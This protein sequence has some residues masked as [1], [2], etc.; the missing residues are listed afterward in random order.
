MICLIVVGFADKY[1]GD[2][3]NPGQK[4]EFSEARIKEILP[5]GFIKPIEDAPKKRTA[6]SRKA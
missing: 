5:Y 1:T 6:K 2:L 4:V 3:Y